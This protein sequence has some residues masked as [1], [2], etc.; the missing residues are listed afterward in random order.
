M[1]S[2]RNS[3]EGISP[4]AKIQGRLLI[5][6][7]PELPN[8]SS[9]IATQD[10]VVY[11]ILTSSQDVTPK[12]D[13]DPSL[14]IPAHEGKKGQSH[15]LLKV[16]PPSVDFIRRNLRSGRSVCIV[17]ETGKDLSVGVALVALQL[18]FAD[19]GSFIPQE[20]DAADQGMP[21]E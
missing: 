8:A 11:V 13:P 1:V 16:L 18:F 14:F 19:D 4:I 6:A 20:G 15:F 21:L 7:V 17:C 9:R 10:Q 12:T 2:V 3:Y 5:G